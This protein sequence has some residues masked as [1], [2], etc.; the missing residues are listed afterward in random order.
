MANIVDT[1]IQGEASKNE[2]QK[3]TSGN[4]GGLNVKA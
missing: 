2:R 1:I 4:L 3:L